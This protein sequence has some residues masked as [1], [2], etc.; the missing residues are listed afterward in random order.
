[1]SAYKEVTT[2]FRNLDSLKKALA[3][4]GFGHCELGASARVNDLQLQ[5]YGGSRADSVALRLPKSHY[6]GFED[7]GFA[8]DAATQSYRAIISAHDGYG[9]F[10]AQTLQRVKQRYAYHEIIAQAA[11]KGYTVREIK[12]TDGVIR[13][14]LS[15][16]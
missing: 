8:W 10:G 15:H 11:R 13:L 3:D 16:R 7:T 6:R 2:E 1:M 14:Q 12:S 4:C 5:G 9:N